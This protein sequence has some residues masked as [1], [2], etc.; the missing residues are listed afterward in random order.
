MA[1]LKSNSI[2][3]GPPRYS[4]EKSGNA[5]HAEGAGPTPGEIYPVTTA[6]ELHREMS[7]RTIFMLGIGGGVGTRAL[8]ACFSVLSSTALSSQ[9]STTR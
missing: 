8:P 5:L 6:S 1:V 2:S 7:I 9:T 4:L 3:K